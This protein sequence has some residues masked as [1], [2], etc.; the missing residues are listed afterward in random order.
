M[1]RR[2]GENPHKPISTKPLKGQN[3]NRP[4]HP[5]LNS[6]TSVEFAQARVVWPKLQKSIKKM[7]WHPPFTPSLVSPHVPYNFGD[8]IRHLN[9]WKRQVL[10]ANARRAA[11]QA[12]DAAG[13][14]STAPAAPLDFGSFHYR[15]SPSNLS[16][17][18]CRETVWCRDP[19][20]TWRHFA[21]WP[22]AGE[23]ELEG[24]A[25]IKTENH[26]YGRFLPLPRVPPAH[27][28]Y[29]PDYTKSLAL[30]VPEFDRTWPAPDH[31]SILAPVDEIDEDVV[32]QLLD[33][34]ILKALDE[35]AYP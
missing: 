33:A 15:S 5:H 7:Y 13:R 23:F 3:Q 19:F 25:R 18:L 8:Y 17:V 22:V 10:D 1:A 6:L 28:G 2:F 26:I 35:D 4:A 12:L 32:P 34:D 27:P 20:V 30:R 16:T 24:N 31:E 29:D 11:R 21:E 9:E 14:G